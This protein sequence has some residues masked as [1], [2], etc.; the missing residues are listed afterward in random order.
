MPP[1]IIDAHVHLWN[2]AELP[3][4]WLAGI[5]ALNQPFGLAEYQEA[6][7]DVPIAG[8]V[9]VETDVAPQFAVLEAER[10]VALAPHAPHLRGIVAAAPVEYGAPTRAYLAALQRLGPLIKGVRR[11]LQSETDPHFCLKD[12]F[13]TGVHLLADYDW[14]FDLCIRHDQLPAATELVRRSPQVRFVLDHLGKPPIRHQQL[15]PWRDDLARLA[16]LPNV[17]CKVS[18]VLTEADPGQMR[19]ADIAPYVAH[20]LTVFGPARTLFG[21]DW[22]VL[23]LAAS[24]QQW[25]RLLVEVLSSLAAEAQQQFW[26]GTAQTV[27]RL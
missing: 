26:G 10:V 6:T 21:G 1:A 20:A 2:P 7:T 5:P 9:Y 11:N 17:W 18:G 22:P 8:M 19:P 14:S 25:V 13:I 23:R 12:D 16:Q 24:Y 27:Y 15:D 3:L 4:P